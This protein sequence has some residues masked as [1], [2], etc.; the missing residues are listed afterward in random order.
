MLTPLRASIE[1]IKERGK[2]IK[3]AD[4]NRS[5]AL[6]VPEDYRERVRMGSKAKTD[7]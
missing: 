1:R 3:N 4:R 6:S 2:A 5:T 7:L